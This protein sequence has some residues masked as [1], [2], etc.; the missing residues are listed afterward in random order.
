MALTHINAV[1]YASVPSTQIGGIPVKLEP[2]VFD[3]TLDT[4]SLPE[5]T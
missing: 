2:K 3:F 5:S 4:P 1:L